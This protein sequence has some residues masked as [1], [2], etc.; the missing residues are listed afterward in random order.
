MAA[1]A[2]LRLEDQRQEQLQGAREEERLHHQAPEAIEA[3]REQEEQRVAR[4]KLTDRD[5]ETLQ[6]LINK[7]RQA[8]QVYP[9]DVY[10]G[11]GGEYEEQPGVGM[12]TEAE[13][14]RLKFEQ[15]N[16]LLRASFAEAKRVLEKKD[17]GQVGVLEDEV[18]K[19][20]LF[21]GKVQSGV[22][23]F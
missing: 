20:S 11:G 3:I 17:D 10:N 6:D 8:Q 15:R 19:V 12:K 13:M 2:Q 18:K 7:V 23:F 22:L 21:R 14:A 9:D 5:R 1:Q 4:Q 16:K